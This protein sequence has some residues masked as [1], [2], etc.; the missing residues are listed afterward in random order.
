MTEQE[1]FTQSGD[2]YLR[3]VHP[4]KP[5]GPVLGPL[6]TLAPSLPLSLVAQ[7]IV[8]ISWRERL[9]GL[10]LAMAQLSEGVIEKMLNSLKDVRGISIVPTCAALATLARHGLFDAE[11]LNSFNFDVTAF[12]GEVGWAIERTLWYAQT[13]PV[14]VLERGPNYGQSF[15]DH[16]EMYEWILSGRHDNEG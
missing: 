4:V 14:G 9:L 12:D 16:V 10:S 8:G 13:Q 2:A 7:M 11:R 3:L 6:L 1:V 15:A 5:Y